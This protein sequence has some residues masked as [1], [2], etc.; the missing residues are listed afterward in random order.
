MKKIY[1]NRQCDIFGIQCV[2]SVNIGKLQ[3]NKNKLNLDTC[4]KCLNEGRVKFLS[5]VA[6]KSSQKDDFE[7]V[8]TK[9]KQQPSNSKFQPGWEAYTRDVEGIEHGEAMH[10][11]GTGGGSVLGVTHI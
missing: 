1:E 7:S 2:Y 5:E 3:R 8:L 10:V 11:L 6:R 9:M 4:V